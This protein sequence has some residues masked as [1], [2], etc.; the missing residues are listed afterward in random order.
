MASEFKR[1]QAVTYTGNIC[2]AL[3]G[4]RGHVDRISR[5]GWVMVNFE[6]TLGEAACS[7]D[8]LEPGWGSCCNGVGCSSRRDEDTAC[9]GVGGCFGLRNGIKDGRPFDGLTTFAG[10]GATNNIG[11]GSNHVARMI[12]SFTPCNTLHDYSRSAI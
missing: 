12:L 5:K 3:T 8:S 6:G 1:G 9:I 10:R 7:P 2:P 4:R 11:S